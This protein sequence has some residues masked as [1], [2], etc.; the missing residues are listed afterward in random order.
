MMSLFRIMKTIKLLFLLLAL[1]FG[2][3]PLMADDPGF[4]AEDSQFVRVVRNDD[5]SRSIFQRT[6]EM[7]GGMKKQMF[8]ANGVLLSVT[9]YRTGK[10]GQLT[11]CKIYDGKGNEMYKVAYGYDKNT[12]RLV[13]EKMYDSKTKKIVR[14]FVYTYDEQGNRS[15]PVAVS[16]PT[17]LPD[18]TSD[19]NLPAPSAPEKDPFAAKPVAPAKK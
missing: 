14:L 12:A 11:S 5:G 1:F 8:D 18:E 6:P 13:R 15:K 16:Y 19:K 7:K 3:S 2:V 17:N 9:M 4:D 10:W